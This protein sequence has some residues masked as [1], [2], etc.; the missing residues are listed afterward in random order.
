[1]SYIIHCIAKGEIAQA[2]CE[3]YRNNQC[4]FCQGCNVPTQIA[5][6]DEEAIRADVRGAMRVDSL[7]E[8]SRRW[9]A[10]PIEDRVRELRALMVGTGFR[11]D[12]PEV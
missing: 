12:G 3:Q 10:L 7:V 9:K 4:S 11:I 2:R 6:A 5:A 1:M 8:E